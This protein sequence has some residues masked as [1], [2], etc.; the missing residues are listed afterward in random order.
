MH[1]SLT[2]AAYLCWYAAILRA[3]A[4]YAKGRVRI[5][6]FEVADFID[7]QAD[8]ARVSADTGSSTDWTQING[9]HCPAI[10][11]ANGTT[12]RWNRVG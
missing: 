6:L 1:K 3:Y 4:R 10:D 12:I 8:I 2:K 9:V 7:L 11:T 5:R